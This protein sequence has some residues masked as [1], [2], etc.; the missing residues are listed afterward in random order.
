MSRVANFANFSNKLSNIENGD[1]TKPVN[2]V[3]VVDLP[4]EKVRPD[5]NNPRKNFDQEELSDLA[6][7]IK[8]YGL[9]QAIE[10]GEADSA[11][12]H[13]ILCGERRYRASVLIGNKTIRAVIGNKIEAREA[14]FRQIIENDQRAP[15][16]AYEMAIQIDAFLK[17]GMSQVDI[18]KGLGRGKAII[19]RY[20]ALCSL[21]PA[22]QAVAP[23]YG[24]T[25]L[26]ELLAAWNKNPE[27]VESYIEHEGVSN[28]SRRTLDI[29]MAGDGAHASI[30]K[31]SEAVMNKPV[32]EE[33]LVREVDAPVAVVNASPTQTEQAKSQSEMSQEPFAVSDEVIEKSA[34]E[35]GHVS[36]PVSLKPILKGKTR[37]RHQFYGE[38]YLVYD[39]P[40]LGGEI[41]AWF[42]QTD[43]KHALTIGEIELIGT[44]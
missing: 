20:V 18:A 16:T 32:D 12:I 40:M 36:Q 24:L 28:L 35:N 11:G 8:A 6:E 19:S 1:P 42:D 9:I 27:A 29:V 22:L 43:E 44:E 31:P 38:G 5:P 15:L 14:R 30:V 21:P 13:T 26:T 25:M 34:A 2:G 37:V 33:V 39:Q 4:I 10:V 23:L 7:T 17:E 3:S 41:I